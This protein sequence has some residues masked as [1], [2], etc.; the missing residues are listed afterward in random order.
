MTRPHPRVCNSLWESAFEEVGSLPSEAQRAFANARL[1][2][3]EKLYF[4]VRTTLMTSNDVCLLQLTV[5]HNEFVLDVEAARSQMRGEVAPS[6]MSQV[7][8]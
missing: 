5:A 2:A 3:M 4:A 6:L 8:R 1:A 7:F